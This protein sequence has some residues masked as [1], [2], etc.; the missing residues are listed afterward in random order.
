MALNSTERARR[1]GRAWAAAATPEQRKQASRRAY[2]SGAANTVANRVEE[3]TD[4]QLG[5]LSLAVQN[6]LATRTTQNEG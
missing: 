1:G 6:E 3:L 5:A 4:E 2:L